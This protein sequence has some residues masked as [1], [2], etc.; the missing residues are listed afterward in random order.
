MT[1]P[2]KGTLSLSWCKLDSDLWFLCG[3]NSHALCWNPQTLKKIRSSSRRTIRRSISMGGRITPDL[4]A[5]AFLDGAVSVC[6]IQ[7]TVAA[8]AMGALDMVF[9][10]LL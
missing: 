1:R 6:L 8:V 7:F 10:I 4:F 9:V 3:K 5:A 2:D